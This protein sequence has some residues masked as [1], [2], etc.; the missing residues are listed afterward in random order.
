LNYL[1]KHIA[2]ILAL[3]LLF[4]PFQSSRGQQRAKTPGLNVICIDPGHGGHDP[5]CV[6]RDGKNVKE[7]DIVLSVGL[8]LRKYLNEGYPDMKVVMTRETDTFIELGE[9][10]AIANRNDANLFISIHINSVD[11][12]KNSKWAGVSGFSVHTLGQSR[13]GRDLYSS[14]MDLCRR[15]N[16][17]ILLESDHDT[18]YQG[19]NPDDP[20]SYIIF[21]L[22][23]NSNLEQSLDFAGYVGAS[24]AK[25][26][27]LKNRGISQD[28]FLVLWKTTMPAVLIECGFITGTS[29]LA[30]LRTESGQDE[31]ARNIYK[32]IIS[33]KKEYDSSVD[34]K[35]VEPQKTSADKPA[36]KAADSKAAETQANA[37]G[38]AAETAQTDAAKTSGGASDNS[39]VKAAAE[40]ETVYGTQIL[41]SAKKMSADDPFFKGE[42]ILVVKSGNLYK[43]V[44]GLGNTPQSAKEKHVA[45]G[46]KFSGAFL[47]KIEGQSI[48][49]LR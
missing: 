4:L 49:R 30:K 8:K 29:D 40:G 33:Y 13:T 23:Q 10:A 47:V 1:Q 34:V 41:A 45:L 43:Y 24:L 16:S 38:K 27:V 21:N 18:K 11:P 25:G 35:P 3:A 26:P 32:A 2:A 46:K 17:V 22:M 15:E 48:E 42:E 31:I 36:A 28:P 37:K 7:K 44:A 12:K 19:F 9:R 14:N 6:S 20:E 39:D 5:G